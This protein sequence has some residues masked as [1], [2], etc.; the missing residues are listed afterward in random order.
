MSTHAEADFQRRLQ[1][2]QLET[3]IEIGGK[4]FDRLPWGTGLPGRRK[5]CSCGA[6]H[7]WLHQQPCQHEVC[8]LCRGALLEC[9]CQDAPAARQ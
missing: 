6:P 2:A 8:P 7:G 4:E 5:D 3:T 1:A 9:G